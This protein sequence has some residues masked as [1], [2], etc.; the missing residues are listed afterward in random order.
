[1]INSKSLK[2]NTG[3]KG[4]SFDKRNGKFEISIAY[5]RKFNY[6]NGDKL[7]SVV[8]RHYIGYS[9]TLNEAVKARE[10]FIK[11]LF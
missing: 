4:I 5:R 10:D 7:R 11:S 8:K 1:M 9:E 6:G 2:S 3:F